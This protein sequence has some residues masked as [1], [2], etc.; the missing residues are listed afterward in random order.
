MK[1]V[2][3]KDL[4]VI[5]YRFVCP[6]CGNETII[7][8]SSLDEREGIACLECFKYTNLTD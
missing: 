4:E 7:K 8:A 1:K 5:A 3:R 6:H 2:S